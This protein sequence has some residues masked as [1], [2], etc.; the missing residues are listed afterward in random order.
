MLLEGSGMIL[1]AGSN[2]RI[3]LKEAFR[4]QRFSGDWDVVGRPLGG[5][6]RDFNLMVRRGRAGGELKVLTVANDLELACPNDGMLIVHVLR[7]N[8]TKASRGETL[9]ADHDLAVAPDS[10]GPAVIAL[11]TI[12]LARQRGEGRGPASLICIARP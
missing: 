12:S 3:E 11:V 7:G 6:V 10:F 8:L 9:V 5:P 4:P 1:D 2:G